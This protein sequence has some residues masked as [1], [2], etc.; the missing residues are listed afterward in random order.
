M[1]NLIKYIAH[2][3]SFGFHIL[4]ILQ[5][6]LGASLF[7]LDYNSLQYNTECAVN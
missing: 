1:T 4:L 6:V 7:L 2:E 3:N 5:F